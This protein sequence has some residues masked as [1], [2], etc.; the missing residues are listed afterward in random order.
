MDYFENCADAVLDRIALRLHVDERSVN[1]IARLLRS[2]ERERMLENV[3]AFARLE[4]G[5]KAARLAALNVLAVARRHLGSLDEVTV[6]RCKPSAR[7]PG[8]A[9]S[10]F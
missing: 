1:Y 9:G 2:G 4:A 8:R 3:N 7:R 5:R 10:H 6:W